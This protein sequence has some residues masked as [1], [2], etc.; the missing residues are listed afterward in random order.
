MI[1]AQCSV[2]TCTC[3]LTVIQTK[4]LVFSSYLFFHSFFLRTLSAATTRYPSLARTPQLTLTAFPPNWTSKTFCAKMNHCTRRAEYWP[5]VVTILTSYDSF[6]SLLPA[7]VRN[8]ISIRAYYMMWC[9]NRSRCA[10]KAEMKNHFWV[11]IPNIFESKLQ[12]TK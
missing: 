6:W 12:A 4:E 1:E 11:D 10:N 7:F 8:S 9:E 2:D 5:K 3:L